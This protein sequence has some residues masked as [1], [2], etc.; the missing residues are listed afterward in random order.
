MKVTIEKLREDFSRDTYW[1]RIYFESDDHQK[2]STVLIC[3][4]REYLWDLFKARKPE[5]VKLEQWLQDAIK[6]WGFLGDKIFERKVYYDVYAET[7][8]GRV[9]G[10]EF[11]KNEVVP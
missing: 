5:E 2:E 11:L 4:S 6:K 3:A 10:L 9:N 1:T 7:A 8:E